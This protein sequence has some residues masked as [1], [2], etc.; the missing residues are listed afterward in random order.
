MLVF[1]ALQAK[2]ALSTVAVRVHWPGVLILVFAASVAIA[3]TGI[4]V[5]LCI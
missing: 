3:V 2:L 1:L 5:I 4:D